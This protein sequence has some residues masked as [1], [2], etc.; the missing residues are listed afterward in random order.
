LA[1]PGIKVYFIG[2][3]LYAGL[4][5]L[6]QLSSSVKYRLGWNTIKSDDL[7]YK[8]AKAAEVRVRAVYKNAQGKLLS[9]EFGDKDAPLETIV[10]DMEDDMKLLEQKALT[11]ARK[12]RYEGYEG[13]IMAFLQP[14]AQHGYKA[15]LTDDIYQDRSGEYLTD[16][17]EINF[18]T[19]GARRIVE[20][21]RK[22]L[23]KA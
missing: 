22:I 6:T 18:G 7:K 20:I 1:E 4:Q 14:F 9:K 21:G 2:S 10:F 23:S 12:L 3:V 17:V 16:S 8:T 13:K 19:K 15:V 11:A 5:E